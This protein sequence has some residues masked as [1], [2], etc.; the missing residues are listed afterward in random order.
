MMIKSGLG[1]FFSLAFQ[2]VNGQFVWDMDCTACDSLPCPWW[3]LHC[4]FCKTTRDVGITLMASGV[5]PCEA[6]N[7][8]WEDDAQQMIIDGKDRLVELGV[9][10]RSF[11]DSVDIRWCGSLNESLPGTKALT[12]SGDMFWVDDYFL[13]DSSSTFEKFLGVLVHEFVHITQ[14]RDA[15]NDGISENEIFCRFGE[16]GIENSLNKVFCNGDIEGPACAAACAA[17]RLHPEFIYGGE[18]C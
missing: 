17:Q 15:N 18:S 3:N 9:L 10:E 16:T 4:H 1:L 14:W 12:P 2:V 11:V 5:D 7:I 13:S 6:E 8:T